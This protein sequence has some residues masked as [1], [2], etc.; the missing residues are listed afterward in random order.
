MGGG[1]ISR[2]ELPSI[3]MGEERERA[4]LLGVD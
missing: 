4:V 1:T 2:Y 3:F